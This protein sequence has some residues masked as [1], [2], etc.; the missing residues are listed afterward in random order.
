MPK[1]KKKALRGAVPGSSK[2]AVVYARASA[3]LAGN[4]RL[5]A[6]AARVS[7]PGSSSSASDLISGSPIADPV[8]NVS[9]GVVPLSDPKLFVPTVV[10]TVD[11]FAS[12]VEASVVT[13]ANTVLLAG[14]CVQS[15]V[16]ATDLVTT[17]PTASETIP[18]ASPVVL[19]AVVDSVPL[20][21]T[22]SSP[23]KVK[24]SPTIANL[25]QSV[26]SDS[27][28]DMVKGSSRKLSKKGTGFSLPSGE[29]SEL[30]PK[31]IEKGAKK[32]RNQRRRRSLTPAQHR[33]G[34]E[35]VK[36]KGIAGHEWQI[37][38]STGND[39]NL[40]SNANG[41]AGGSVLS[42]ALVTPVGVCK[43][44]LP[45]ESSHSVLVST[46]SETTSAAGGYESSALLSVFSCT[47]WCF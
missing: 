22:P 24:S 38:V 17:S 44:I 32:R 35:I 43:Q 9:S 4:S 20:V 34:K 37:K 21:K 19:A 13:A 2:F 42:K 41:S 7:P 47:S 25:A 39:V 28:V 36:V 1:K 5:V 10:S 8:S 45:G 6:P 18:I 26:G 16:L 11:G 29:L 3:A 14:S 40:I 30:C 33:E 31:L 15:T 12:G 27:W 46:L 23:V